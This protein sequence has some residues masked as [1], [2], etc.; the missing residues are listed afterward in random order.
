MQK[1]TLFYYHC[2]NLESISYEE[3]KANPKY[4]DS[5]L[6]RGYYWLRREV[7]FNPLFLAV[8]NSEE[9]IRMTGYPNQWNRIIGTEIVR[10]RKD[11]SYIQKNILRKRGEFP[12]YVLFS[13]EEVEGVFMDYGYWHLVLNAHHKNYN[14]S[15]YEKRL[16]FKPSWD[17]SK[18]LK[19]A[20]KEPHSVQ[21]VTRGLYLPDA[22]GIFVRNQGTKDLLEKIGFENVKI[23][24]LSVVDY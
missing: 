20:R 21:L 19:K 7:G 18:W 5:D 13:F 8:G 22:R 9:D 15:D 16:I 2:R 12:N 24:R 17:K 3:V 23:K 1:S 10:R 11:G 6:R 4:F 14:I